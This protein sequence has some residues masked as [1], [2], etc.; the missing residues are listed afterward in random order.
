MTKQLKRLCKVV[1]EKVVLCQLIYGSKFSPDKKKIP[2]LRDATSKLFPILEKL[3]TVEP[4]LRL[5]VS[6][7][8]KLHRWNSSNPV[9]RAAMLA[10]DWESTCAQQYDAMVNH[11]IWIFRFLMKGNQTEKR[12]ERGKK[13][14]HSPN[15]DI[16]ETN[17]FTHTKK[18]PPSGPKIK[19]IIIISRLNLVPR[20]LLWAKRRS[21]YEITTKCRQ[22]LF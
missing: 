8:Q 9:R 12:R 16:V 17:P 22:S 10:T 4:N 21:G 11:Y 3:H 1:F 14:A 6:L 5:S 7:E 20:S 18:N 13:M 19:L 2:F 15:S